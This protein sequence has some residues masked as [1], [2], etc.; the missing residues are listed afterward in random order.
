MKRISIIL[1][2]FIIT[3][4]LSTGQSFRITGR[5]LEKEENY[6]IAGVAIYLKPDGGQTSSDNFGNY[7]LIA[8]GGIKQISARVLGYK[9]MTLKFELRSDTVIDLYMQI[10]LYEL[11]EVKVISDSAKSIERTNLGN[12]IITPAAIRET[13]RLFS[14]PDLLKSLQMLPGV[15]FGKEG[16]SDI[17]VRGGG[18]G[19]NIIIA[20]GCYFFLPGHLLG[21][22]SPYDLDFLESAEFY[23][24]YIPSDIGG[25]AS[26]I[27]DLD[28]RKPHTDSLSA[29]IR[30]G[31]LSS[32]LTLDIPFNRINLDLTAGLKR[33]NYS[34]Y[35][36]LLKKIVPTDV[37]NFLPP[38]KYSFYDSF[39]KLSHESA[40]LGKIS[41]LFFGNYDNGKDENKTTGQRADTLLK[42]TDG[43][44]TGWNSMVH[45]LQWDPPFKSNYI[46]K[47]TL[48]Y[49]RLSIGRK[50]YSGSESFIDT[51]GQK[52]STS[53]T[54]YS[55]YPTIHNIG[56]SVTI[57]RI[58]NKATVS[59]G[60][61]DRFRYFVSNNYATNTID[62]EETRNDL[63]GN[64]LVNETSFFFSATTSL[65]ENFQIDAGI[66]LSGI[67]IRNGSF[68]VPEPRLR[69]SY[70]PGSRISPHI[71]FVRLSQD[72][73]SV[74]GS[75]AG[76]RTQLWLPLYKDFGPEISDVLSAGIQGQIKN[77]FVWSLDGYLKRTSGMLDFK[78]GAS[79][80]FDSSFVDLVDK[81]NL[82]AYGIEAG[83]IK[84]TGKLTGNAS[85]TW[86]R[87]KREWYAPEG[88]MWIPSTADRPHNFNLSLKYCFK[89]KTSFGLNFVYQSGAPATIY[90]HET[91]YGEFFETKNNIRY[92]DYHRLD[93][94]IRQLLLKRKFTIFLDADIY[95]VYNRR[96]TFYFKKT[97]NENTKSYYFK[98]IS[99]FPIMPSL[100]LTIKY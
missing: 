62:G 74:E 79:F 65:S 3:G 71:N 68:F 46:W 73:H 55:F 59:A 70:K 9:P 34:L 1:V 58:F 48:N 23:K 29:Q 87:S 98:N 90:M 38:D 31:L 88:L 14:E 50:I 8:S 4:S 57:S 37:G 16:T 95:N 100:T 80:I 94:S 86:S 82:R 51:T 36:P 56:S 18:P 27:I 17:Y 22:V 32:V 15:S 45:A 91:S 47:V 67:I 33:G 40:K 99:L 28:F 24:D 25:G 13:P 7:S 75:N 76:L 69:F 41:Y 12:F 35:A 26:S 64:D 49:N 42:Y 85:Y 43:I 78:P 72:D 53:G 81:I 89:E 30:L 92:F 21:I 2:F 19:Q 10:S 83:V 61:S 6:L 93:L 96:N 60:V 52:I 77:D 66:R 44:S 5:V 11:M 84:R 54:L 39:V 20:D 97:Y 63:G